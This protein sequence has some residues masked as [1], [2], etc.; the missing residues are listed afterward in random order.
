MKS[1]TIKTIASAIIML[2][3]LSIIQMPSLASTKENVILKKADEE[4]IIYYKDICN[5]EFQ[6][7]F[8]KTEGVEESTL[9]FTNAAKDQLTEKALYVAYLDDSNY[10][11]SVENNTTYI[12]VKDMEDNTV[13]SGEKINLLDVLNDE[14]IEL[15]NNTTKRI[16]VDTT[17]IQ[18]RNTM[19]DGVDTTIT[20][21][22]IVINQ[23]E[24]AKYSYQ[25]I[26]LTAD[27]TEANKL[28]ELAE[29]LKDNKDNTY[30]N[31]SLTKQFYDL[32][33]QLMPTDWTEVDNFEIL[34]PEEAREGDK[35]IV[36][37]KEEQGQTS[38]IDA[39]FLVCRYE[40][41]QGK[42]QE[43]K[44]ITE[45]VKLPVTYDS[46]ALIVAL[47]IIILAIIIVA[48]L[49]LKSNKKEKNS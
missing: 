9:S 4:F 49:K 8:S 7:A 5:N 25:L 47:A 16:D 44:T 43:E 19:I 26:K 2:M 45:T 40:E 23:K 39:K 11:E 3:L 24:N 18:K 41:D 6:F 37:I 10:S 32:Y 22:K 33:T 29:E 1:S 36:Y 31:L 15:V 20:T 35:Y 13:I 38:T 28:F 21:G 12:W 46:I 48:I 27:T 14:S 42:N 30:A 17:Q 34:Q